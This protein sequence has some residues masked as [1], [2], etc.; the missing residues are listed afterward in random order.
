MQRAKNLGVV[1]KECSELTQEIVQDVN[2]HANR[3]NMN[4]Q[5]FLRAET[6]TEEQH[7]DIS[8]AAARASV[9]A[10][11]ADPPDQRNIDDSAIPE[12]KMMS[13]HCQHRQWGLV[14]NS[15]RK[16][17]ALIVTNPFLEVFWPCFRAAIAVF[18]DDCAPICDT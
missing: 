15:E 16:Q 12:N 5:W 8:R 11:A 18:N 17:R 4:A 3:K 10:A 1:S 9:A 14:A 13:C 2:L 7:K 6:T